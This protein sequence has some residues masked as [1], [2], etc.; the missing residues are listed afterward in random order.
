MMRQRTGC[1]SPLFRQT[2]R[3]SAFITKLAMR[4][5]ASAETLGLRLRKENGLLFLML[6]TGLPQAG[7]RSY[8]QLQ[9]TRIW[10]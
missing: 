4:A 8:L 6:M 9:N 3:E 7:S 5:Q 1:T 2:T 10:T